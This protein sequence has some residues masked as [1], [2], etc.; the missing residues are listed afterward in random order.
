LSTS[1]QAEIFAIRVEFTGR[2]VVKPN[3]ILCLVASLLASML[4]LTGVP[5]V[6]AIAPHPVVRLEPADSTVEAGSTFTVT[7]MMDE[8]DD[9]GAFQ[10]NLHYTPSIVQVEAITLADFLAGTGRAVHP[11][12]PDIVNSTGF[13]R[14][15]GF[16]Y[17]TQPGPDGT[18]PL[19]LLRLR[20][21]GV[22]ASPLDLEGVKVVDT[23]AHSK[24]HRVEDGG[25]TVKGGAEYRIYLPLA[26][27]DDHV[28]P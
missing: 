26:L 2:M 15:G 6:G 3:R 13:A 18:G 14:F 1:G 22:G 9:L 8:A 4:V 16:S 23:Q 21:V 25:A 11:L 7:V 19:A 28:Q 24:V 12:G 20:V 27:Q 17:G 10:F 5:E